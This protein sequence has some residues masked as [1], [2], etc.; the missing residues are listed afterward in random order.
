MRLRDFVFADF[1]IVYTDS[2]LFFV[3]VPFR[4]GF[5]TAHVETTALDE[6]YLRFE[7]LPRYISMLLL[8]FFRQAFFFLLA[9]RGFALFAFLLFALFLGNTL[10]FL[11][12]QAFS[13]RLFLATS[14]SRGFLI[15][16]PLSLFFRKLFFYF[17]LFALFRS[18][19]LR[20]FPAT[21]FSRRVLV[22]FPLPLFFRDP[23]LFLPSR[24]LPQPAS[25]L[26]GDSFQPRLSRPFRVFRVQGFRVPFLGPFWPG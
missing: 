1:E 9:L 13:L 5:G 26:P 12:F 11:L 24:A 20:L 25:P 17:L 2:V 19:P 7:V 3:A 10:G 22:S 14:F 16:F 4:F 6:F 23:F 15:L 18:G 21:F 8:L